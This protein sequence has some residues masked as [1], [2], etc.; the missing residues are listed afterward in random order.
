M[1]TASINLAARMCQIDTHTD[2][3]GHIGRQTDRNTD[4]PAERQT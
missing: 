2:T 4:R 3:D 1:M